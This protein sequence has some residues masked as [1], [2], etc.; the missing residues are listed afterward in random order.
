MRRPEG[1]DRNA[2]TAHWGRECTLARRVQHRPDPEV[3]ALGEQCISGLPVGIVRGRKGSG[4]ENGRGQNVPHGHTVGLG[5][6]GVGPIPPY[7]RAESGGSASLISA[8]VWVYRLPLA[9]R[10]GLGAPL[11]AFRMKDHAGFPH[12]RHVTLG[13]GYATA[14]AAQ[15]CALFLSARNMDYV[16]A[17]VE[18]RNSWL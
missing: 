17:L 16:C 15:Q 5:F 9:L 14:R 8:S 2:L 12:R 18:K 13:Y 3:R 10:D 4:S 7:S 11:V 1:E 6:S